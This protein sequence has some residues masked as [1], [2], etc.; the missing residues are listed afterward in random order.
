MTQFYITQVTK[1]MNLKWT[2]VNWGSGARRLE[3]ETGGLQ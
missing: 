1:Q 2:E 3:V